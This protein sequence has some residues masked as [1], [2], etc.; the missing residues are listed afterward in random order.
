MIIIILAF[1]PWKSGSWGSRASTVTPVNVRRSYGPLIIYNY[2][3]FVA[4]F[5]SSSI[6]VLYLS[7]QCKSKDS[8]I[9]PSNQYSL[10]IIMTPGLLLSSTISLR[11]LLMSSF[12]TLSTGPTSSRTWESDQNHNRSDHHHHHHHHG[13]PWQPCRQKSPRW[14]DWHCRPPIVCSGENMF[15]YHHRHVNI[16]TTININIIIQFVLS[17]RQI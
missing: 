4:I 5:V 9:Q 7:F 3:L 12:A 2:P 8:N 17:K 6:L 11:N 15:L 1:G 14:Q 10:T 16:L 13:K